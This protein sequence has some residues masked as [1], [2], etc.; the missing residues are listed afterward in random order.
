MDTRIQPLRSES[1]V[2]I[3]G[4]SID[5]HLNHWGLEMPKEGLYMFLTPNQLFNLVDCLLKSHEFAKQ[6]NSDQEQRNLLWKAG[7]FLALACSWH[8]LVPG[9]PISGGLA[10]YHL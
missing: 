5:E 10:R 6:F 9:I 8:W 2:S 3:A 1:S 7:E 4:E